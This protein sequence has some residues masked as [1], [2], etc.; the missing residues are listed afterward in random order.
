[1]DKNT[2]LSAIKELKEKNKKNFKQTFDLII[3]LKD[4]DLKKP[5]QQVDIFCQL[6]H[7]KG[8]KTTVCALI[9]PELTEQAK[10][11]CDFFIA[12]DDFEKYGR[13]PKSVKKLS[14]KYDF[15]IAQANIMAKIASA[16]GK[17]LG[18]RGKMPN[19]K[20]GCVVPPNANLKPLVEKLQSTVRLS[21]KTALMIQT[22][23]G[24]EDAPEEN[25]VNNINT[26]YD[27]VIHHTPKGEHNIRKVLLK[28]TM[29][30]P[31]KIG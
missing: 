13:D 12:I 6:H 8:K 16:F 15:F 27:A 10:T 24:M 26:I 2:I 14:D 4:L 18:R 21:A 31:I 11:A 29:S 22:V 23:V 20:A 30:K 28:L 19:P 7:P 9:G 25:L 3:S 1:M 5:E 17:V